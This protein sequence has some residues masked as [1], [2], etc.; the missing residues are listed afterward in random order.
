[1]FLACCNSCGR[2]NETVY[3]GG[4]VIFDPWGNQLAKAEETETVISSECDMSVV[5]GIRTSINVFA[6]RRPE[7]YNL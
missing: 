6:D 4:S 7:L 1:M 2:A 5:N 3:G